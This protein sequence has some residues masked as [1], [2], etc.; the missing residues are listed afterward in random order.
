MNP[1]KREARQKET[2]EAE[3]DGLRKRGTVTGGVERNDGRRRE[4]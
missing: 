1:R 4:M 2:D 3:I